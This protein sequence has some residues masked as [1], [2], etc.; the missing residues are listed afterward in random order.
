MILAVLCFLCVYS[1]IGTYQ[2]EIENDATFTN[3][4]SRFS[5][6]NSWVDSYRMYWS[7]NIHL[8]HFVSFASEYNFVAERKQ[9]QPMQME[10]LRADLIEANKH[11]DTQPWIVAY[12]H[13]HNPPLHTHTHTY[14]Y[15]KSSHTI[16]T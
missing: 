4:R 10:W 12:A 8:I 1:C 15:C 6:P 2:H 16:D 14:I 11:R 9:Y 7:V 13:R 5:M 3:Y